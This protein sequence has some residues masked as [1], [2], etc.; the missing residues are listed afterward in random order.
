MKGK[1]IVFMVLFVLLVSVFHFGISFGAV[2]SLSGSGSFAVQSTIDWWPMFHHD[3][4]HTGFSPSTAPETNHT[5]WTSSLE[6]ASN[7]L[8]QPLLMMQST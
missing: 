4:S 7:G 2:D 3:L 8:P 5:A 6:V 1:A